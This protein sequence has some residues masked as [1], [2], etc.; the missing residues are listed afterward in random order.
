MAAYP[1]AKLPRSAR[2]CERFFGRCPDRGVAWLREAGRRRLSIKAQRLKAR[3]LHTGDPDQVF[4]EELFAAF[5][6]AKNSVPF[7]ALAERLPLAQLPFTEEMAHEALNSAAELEIVRRHPWRLS[8]VR[9]SNAP[10]VRLADAAAIFT[11]GKP[12]HLGANL[13]AAILANVIVPFALARGVLREP[14]D[15]LPPEGQNAVTRLTAFRL[16]GRDHNP[17]L[18]AGNGVL[19][20]GLIQ[21]HREFCLPAHPDCAGCAL[22][23]MPCRECQERE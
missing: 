9:P 16:F 22:G 18:Y 3:C 8:N 5:G 20:Q 12:R 13:S 14:P 7:R 19:L 15:W 6:Y 1:Y 17:S 10:R 23:E 4:Y 2:P 11:G 21:I